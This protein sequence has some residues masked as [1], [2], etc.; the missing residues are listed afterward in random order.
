L[1]WFSAEK[2]GTVGPGK[3]IARTGDHFQ[4]QLAILNNFARIWP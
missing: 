2:A 3:T 4:H 1:G